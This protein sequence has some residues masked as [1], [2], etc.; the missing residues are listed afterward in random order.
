MQVR[1][2]LNGL[3]S[4]DEL[5]GDARVCVAVLDGPVDLSH[6][7]FEGADLT[8]LN[9]LVQEGAG[10]GLM[11][12]H[13]THVTSLL[14]GRSAGEV[15][16]MVPRCRGLSLPVFR[17]TEGRVSQLDLA[18]AIE[19][20]VQHGAHIVNI[21]GGQRTT[22]GQ[23]EVILDRALR[24]CADRGVLVVAAVG[25]DGCDCHQAPAATQSVL[26]VGATDADGNPLEFN[27]WGSAYR[28]N[29]VV[30]P[31]QDIIGAVPGGGTRALTGS[32][33]ATPAVSGVAALLVAE[34]LRQGRPLDPLAAGQAIITA[35]E[36]PE[37][38]PE[39][40][41]HCRRYLAGRLNVPRA[42]T[43]ISRGSTADPDTAL[44][45]EPEGAVARTRA[46]V[47][48]AGQPDDSE[49]RQAREGAYAMETNRPHPGS[50]QQ[51]DPVYQDTCACTAACASSGGAPGSGE[52]APPC[53]AP[54]CGC[55]HAGGNDGSTP[56]DQRQPAAAPI[57][58]GDE[59]VP[60]AV[61]PA[62]GCGH[63][64]GSADSTRGGQQIQQSA[65]TPAAS[66]HITAGSA[67]HQ[68]S[69]QP[70]GDHALVAEPGIRA[71]YG[72]E[73]PGNGPLPLVYAVGQINYDFGTEA[74]R[75][76]FRQLMGF[77]LEETDPQGRPVYQEGNPY[78]KYQMR[79]Y[80]SSE[81]W[82]SDKLH[83]IL[84][85]NRSPIYAL[86]AEPSFGM[87]WGGL[88]ERSETRQPIPP[89]PNK[90]IDENYYPPVSRVYKLF[91]D[92]M[93]GHV[94]DQPLKEPAAADQPLGAHDAQEQRGGDTGEH[95][96]AA[97]PKKPRD[98]ISQV[99]IPGVLTGRTVKLF[100]GLT[101]PEVEVD[102]R[103]VFMW[104]ETALV[105]HVMDS[106]KKHHKVLVS[107]ELLRMTIGSFLDKIHFAF[108]NLGQTSADRARNYVG[109]N[110]YA[111]AHEMARGMLSAKYVPGVPNDHLYTLDTITVRKSSFERFG[112]DC[113]DV[114]VSF[115]DP[116]NDR[117]AQVSYLFPV[118]V[119]EK[120][121]ITLGPSHRFLGDF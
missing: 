4:S 113:Q 74:R 99:S 24:M 77:P 70:G 82:A 102:A 91:R 37:C 103:G 68:G 83:W 26:A 72:Q 114:I 27:N 66:G 6:P 28:D 17:D 105:D 107:D 49:H 7:C 18:R 1:S 96:A 87:D 9:T 76:S 79:Q 58:T 101:V 23:S 41:P 119:N 56:G 110:A 35:A 2:V 30:A 111:V 59:A 115:I 116:E 25:N 15:T 67:A 52:A 95:D 14:F 63:A 32:S 90:P 10:Q 5:L 81:P 21:S 108:Q 100:N 43:L 62:C 75:D 8:R 92:A 45:S 98:Y 36:V 19:Q 53:A 44:T 33:F 73:A 120:I 42:Y 54:A 60:P 12:L 88:L 48:A 106:I 46:P 84:E 94:A 3:A 85:I 50:S 109:T 55:G 57:A 11:S 89:D 69:Q 40:A 97:G 121:P 86:V 31:G 112:S 51:T 47:M 29:G 38:A 39:E 13:G 71:A 80:L 118:D 78:D 64:G 65:T 20:A 16:G 22:D 93:W 104:N 61:A 34:Q 117:R